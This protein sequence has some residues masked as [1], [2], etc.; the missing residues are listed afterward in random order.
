MPL[1]PFLHLLCGFPIGK[2]IKTLPH[3]HSNNTTAGSNTPQFLL[4]ANYFAFRALCEKLNLSLFLSI[5]GVV[6]SLY[7]GKAA[8]GKPALAGAVPSA[9]AG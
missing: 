5:C 7:F 8:Q 2:R 1:L 9:R 6:T 4:P 3:S